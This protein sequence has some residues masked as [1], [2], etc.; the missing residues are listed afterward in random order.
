[1]IIRHEYHPVVPLR[2]F[3]GLIL[4][5]NIRNDLKQEMRPSLAQ[6]NVREKIPRT[7]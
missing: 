2:T 4:L 7:I 5:G 1:M 6:E 3:P